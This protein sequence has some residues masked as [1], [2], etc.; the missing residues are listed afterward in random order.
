MISF[1]PFRLLK[2]NIRFNAFRL[3]N[4]MG[5]NI[6]TLFHEMNKKTWKLFT[7]LF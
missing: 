3:S 7:I 1:I 2:K 4:R 5:Q 6:E